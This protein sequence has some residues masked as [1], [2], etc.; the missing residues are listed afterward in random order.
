[1]HDEELRLQRALVAEVHFDTPAAEVKE[2]ARAAAA[3]P[4]IN[5]QQVKDLCYVVAATAEAPR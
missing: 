5:S 1:M 2:A 3:R 4:N